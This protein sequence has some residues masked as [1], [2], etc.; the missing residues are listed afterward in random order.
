MV[1]FWTSKADFASSLWIRN[2]PKSYPSFNKTISST[3]ESLQI[4]K[5]VK[6]KGENGFLWIILPGGSSS[7]LLEHGQPTFRI[8][9]GRTRLR[10]RL[11]VHCISLVTQGRGMAD[12]TVSQ[13][14]SAHVSQCP[15]VPQF[16]VGTVTPRRADP[17]VRQTTS[18]HLGCHLPTWMWDR[19]QGQACW[20]AKS[21][22][23]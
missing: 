1:L 23:G 7:L 8:S 15:A 5:K 21:Q 22:H 20:R 6:I 19:E 17:T 13:S 9:Q 3:V 11:M 16:G 10:S 2:L 18:T 4:K 12:P 14:F